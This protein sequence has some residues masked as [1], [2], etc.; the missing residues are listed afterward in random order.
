MTERIDDAG[1]FE[2]EARLRDA[3]GTP[4]MDPVR[5][6][7]FRVGRHMADTQH[8]P[9]RWPTRFLVLA[10]LAVPA[11][12]ALGLAAV[13]FGPARQVT[14]ILPGGG[15]SPPA[16]S[17]SPPA[18]SFPGFQP[19]AV[20]AVSESEFW[21]LGCPA[22]SQQAQVLHTTD[23]GKHFA[24]TGAISSDARA[25]GDTP[26][27]TVG[28]IRFADP[29]NGWVFGPGLWSTHDGG[30]TWAAVALAGKSDSV[31]LEPAA[32]EAYALVRQ[33]PG[34]KPSAVQLFRT[35]AKSDAWAPATLPA[36]VEQPAALGVHGKTVWVMTGGQA[37]ALFVSHDQ[38]GSWTRDGNP[39]SA[40]LGGSLAP[41]S[42]TTLWAFCA[43]GMMGQPIVS[44]DGGR[45]FAAQPSVPRFVNSAVLGA[46][47][48][49]KVFVA[50]AASPLMRSADG[51]ATYE[52]AIQQ[53]ANGAFTW[54]GFTDA[55]VGYAVE[56][57]VNQ[58]LWRTSDG[59]QTWSPVSFGA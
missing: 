55:N 58:R 6:V 38:G 49:A 24:S 10:A 45:T 22:G 2:L 46:V 39:C 27:Q 11:A 51:G 42:D 34:A 23:A 12:A 30:R 37:P 9:R 1:A 8:T 14:Q 18:E 7:R 19:R 21:V 3:E 5:R 50:S 56:S 53:P 40:D 15:S 52:P 59:G 28:A 25:C 31:S 48:A 17:P 41:A 13:F 16:A 26:A 57:G 4:G 33:S 44:T 29:A 35:P 54:V 47:S 20:S 36:A 43:T 32:G